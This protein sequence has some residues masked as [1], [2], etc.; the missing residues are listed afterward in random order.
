MRERERAF[1]FPPTVEMKHFVQTF[2]V[3]DVFRILL[4]RIRACFTGSFI[5]SS[6]PSSMCHHRPSRVRTRDLI[7]RHLNLICPFISPS[8]RTYVRPCAGLCVHPFCGL[9]A[10]PILQ[11]TCLLFL[12]TAPIGSSSNYTTTHGS[13]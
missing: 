10:S 11:P 8:S 13:H 9:C 3:P 2:S 6:A 4:P 7:I 1:D 12:L 5:R